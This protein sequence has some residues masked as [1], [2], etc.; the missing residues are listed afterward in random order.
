M[1][2]TAQQNAFSGLGS[3]DVDGASDAAAGKAER[4]LRWVDV[5]E[6]K[7]AGVAAVPADHTLSASLLDENS[8]HLPTAPLNGLD[9]AALAP[10]LGLITQHELRPPV[11]W[12]FT[13]HRGEL[14]S[15][16]AGYLRPGS[17]SSCRTS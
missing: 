8:L 13:G 3:K 15:P 10:P 4:L 17:W 5:M 14:G 6:M 16:N 7:R 1:A 11:L 12:A 9:S 2:I